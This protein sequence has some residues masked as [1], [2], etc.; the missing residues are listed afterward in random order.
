MEPPVVCKLFKHIFKKYAQGQEKINFISIIDFTGMTVN[1]CI[2]EI[3]SEKLVIKTM[4]LKKTICQF[5]RK[6]VPDGLQELQV[7][8]NE[9]F[10][11]KCLIASQLSQLEKLDIQTCQRIQLDLLEKFIE[12]SETLRILSIIECVSSFRHDGLDR[13]MKTIFSN[14]STLEEFSFETL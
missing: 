3:R 9:Y 13:L 4:Y 1:E 14:K 12:E 7:N 6:F 11:G 2:A 5:E 10:L 8:D